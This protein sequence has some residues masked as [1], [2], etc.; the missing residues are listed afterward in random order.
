MT[1]GAPSRSRSRAA[2]PVLRLHHRVPLALEHA[3]EQLPQRRVVLHDQHRAVATVA[4][5]HGE[6]PLAVDRLG[7]VLGGPQRIA[8]V[9][10]VHDRQHHHRDVGRRRVRLERAQH[11][12]AVQPRHHHVE[13]DRVRPQLAR[14][15]QPL[16]AASRHR[17]PEPLAS[18]I[19]PHQ[20]AHRGVVVDHQHEAGA[21]GAL[22]D[23]RRGRALPSPARAPSTSTGN[24][25]VKVLPRPG[26]LSTVTSPPISRQSRRDRA[27]P[28]PVP[29]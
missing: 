2:L 24:R 3:P 27:R 5:Q 22:G 18:Q 16:L 19:A 13:R 9:P 8:E 14:E 12:P 20:L 25:T 26:A 7:Q 28:S 29:P 4:R 6:E 15:P 11:G 21:R 23:G 10:V 17:H 1:P